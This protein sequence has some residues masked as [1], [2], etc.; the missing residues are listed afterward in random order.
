MKDQKKLSLEILAHLRPAAVGKFDPAR[1]SRSLKTTLPPL[2]K[3]GNLPPPFENVAYWEYFIPRVKVTDEA[4]AET[5]SRLVFETLKPGTISK[6]SVWEMVPDTV[7]RFCGGRIERYLVW[8]GHQKGWALTVSEA[9][10]LAYN[11]Q[12]TIGIADTIPV[13]RYKEYLDGCS[14]TLDMHGVTESYEVTVKDIALILLTGRVKGNKNNEE[15]VSALSLVNH[16]K[17]YSIAPWLTVTSQKS[18]SKRIVNILLNG[19]QATSKLYRIL[20]PMY[21]NSTAFQRYFGSPSSWSEDPSQKVRE[22]IYNK[23]VYLGLIEQQ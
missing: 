20:V 7:K 11:D 16:L 22:N 19:K 6:E 18:L 13:C 10:M 9:G 1:V 17:I 4:I 5:F 12:E 14:Y 2:L 3:E 15:L 21:M 23:L 8:A